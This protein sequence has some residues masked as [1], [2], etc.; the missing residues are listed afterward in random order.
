[1]KS[2]LFLAIIVMATITMTIPVGAVT[3]DMGPGV[4]NG[5][6]ETP[7]GIANWDKSI[8]PSWGPNGGSTNSW[9]YLMGTG[10][11]LA[12]SDGIQ[13]VNPYSDSG[14]FAS[15]AFDATETGGVELSV[16][17][18]WDGRTD[19]G[20]FWAGYTGM[21]AELWEYDAG[22]FTA[23]NLLGSV[24]GSIV[25]ADF[26]GSAG[27]ITKSTGVLPRI[28]PS[29]QLQVIGDSGII[30]GK[31]YSN[32]IDNIVV[33]SHSTIPPYSILNVTPDN[34]Q[35]CSLATTGITFD[36]NNTGTA[37][38]MTWTASTT[39]TWLSTSGS[40]TDAG[41]F[42]VDATEN[43]TGS[44]RVGTVTV[45]APGASTDT[46]DVTVT[47][48]GTCDCGDEGAMANDMTGPLGVPD[49]KV[50][51]HDFA[52]MARTWLDCTYPDGC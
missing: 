49:C 13:S 4:N 46:K 5:S 26:G 40:G 31:S 33:T 6:F 50:T 11:N 48:L 20:S 10:A 51:L 42:T 16:D 8:I 18:G 39:E 36:V 28:D 47:Q 38:G 12:P 1:M 3:I 29:L 44:T 23:V 9:A 27:W 19:E 45:N 25:E 21:K 17:F 32:Y 43:T 7:G 2:K 24:G 30:G 52:A 14:D 15:V 22:T 41:Q 34:Q 37:T 35:V